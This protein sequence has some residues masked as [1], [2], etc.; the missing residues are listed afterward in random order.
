MGFAVRPARPRRRG[1]PTAH[2]QLAVRDGLLV[3]ARDLFLQ[4]GY[5]AVSARSQQ[6]GDIDP[7]L[8]P[9]H[10]LVSTLSL[11]MWPF[12][13]RPVLSRGLGIELEG[14]SLDSL[15]AHTRGVLTRGVG[16]RP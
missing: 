5:R 15:V 8:T 10:V 13:V 9:E 7:A 3:A 6:A 1:H 14:D 2:D 16:A 11:G 4:Y 12:L